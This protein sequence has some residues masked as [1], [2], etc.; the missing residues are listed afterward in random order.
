MLR[1][2]TASFQRYP[3]CGG[4]RAA[5]PTQHASVSL[6]PAGPK[7]VMLLRVCVLAALLAG[8]AANPPP[9]AHYSPPPARIPAALTGP[10]AT[11]P[12]MPE[13]GRAAADRLAAAIA[14]YQAIAAGGGWGSVP[15][16][17]TA[18]KPGEI[19]LRVPALRARL[20]VTDG[21]PAS[22]PTPY[23]YDEV[24]AAVVRAFQ[25][26]HGLETDGV[27]GRATLEALNVPVE[28][29][30]DAMIRSLAKMALQEPTW[31]ERYIV[32]N[33]A[34]AAYRYVDGGTV[35]A[36]PAI[37]GK[38]TW[39]TPELNSV[40]D[41]IDFNP[42]WTVPHRIA[43]AEIWPKVRKDASYLAKH[44][45]TV[46]GGTIRQRPGPGNPLGQVKFSFD[47]P[48]SV[49][50]HDTNSR[51]LFAKAERHL[52]HGCVRVSDAMTLARMLV[53][54]SAGW[55]EAR[56]DAALAETG[57]THVRLDRPIPVH[58]VYNT[59]WVAEDGTINLRPDVYNR[60][61]KQIIVKPAQ[62]L[63]AD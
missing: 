57:T 45:M 37:V 13:P 55:S 48:Y 28:A 8:C 15:A 51:T 58:I 24:L 27:V 32:V 41:R 63:D 25:A 42:S 39:Q 53:G 61:A 29:R 44:N 54:E 20:A 18:L 12:A 2:G 43:A 21:A 34:A 14:T 19:D 3:S 38:P 11:D 5:A 60:D 16:A 46:A 23:L 52:S 49:Y 40:I 26:R 7:V 6:D 59:A 9:D 50:L 33:A 35:I 4:D 56:I 31:G 10:Q 30:L 22:S 47:N 17:A 36:G 62:Q 1:K